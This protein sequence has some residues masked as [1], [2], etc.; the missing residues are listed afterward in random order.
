MA[1][2]WTEEVTGPSEVPEAAALLAALERYHRRV[3]EQLAV[4]EE[5]L[6]QAGQLDGG[7]DGVAET[8]ALLEAVARHLSLKDG[9]VRQLKGSLRRASGE[10]SRPEARRPPDAPAP[11]GRSA[12]DG[13]PGA[14]RSPASRPTAGEVRDGQFDNA[15]AG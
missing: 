3:V 7:A 9:E 6:D 11:E 13:W 15:R 4:T 12:E 10:A 1:V 14:T 5:L 8:L 2:S